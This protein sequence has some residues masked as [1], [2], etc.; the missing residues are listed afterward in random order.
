M[1]KRLLNLKY[2]RLTNIHIQDVPK[3][4][5]Y[6]MMRKRFYLCSSCNEWVGNIGYYCYKCYKSVYFPKQ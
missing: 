4:V 3:H 6:P 2:V 1:S 5:H